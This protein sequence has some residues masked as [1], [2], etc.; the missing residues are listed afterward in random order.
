MSGS[1]GNDRH[2]PESHACYIEV[3]IMPIYEYQ[4]E[5]CQHVTEFLESSANSTKQ[6]RCEKCGSKDVR[7]LLSVPNVGMAGGSSTASG[8]CP[9]GT[10]PIT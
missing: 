7:K 1:Q 4:C 10:C 3:S 6:H 2:S 5:K 8:S 9:T